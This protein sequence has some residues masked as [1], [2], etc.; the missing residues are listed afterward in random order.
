MKNKFFKKVIAICAV[1]CMSGVSGIMPANAAQLSLPYVNNFD[2]YEDVTYSNDIWGAEEG[3]PLGLNDFFTAGTQGNIVLSLTRDPDALERGKVFKIDVKARQWSFVNYKFEEY[4]TG[5]IL[6]KYDIKADNENKLEWQIK[7]SNGECSL[8]AFENNTATL[9]GAEDKTVTYARGEYNTVKHILD[10]DHKMMT[11]YFNDSS[12]EWAMPYFV[13]D[14]NLIPAFDFIW[15]DQSGTACDDTIYIDNLEIRHITGSADPVLSDDRGNQV[16]VFVGETSELTL[17][18]KNGDTFSSVPEATFVDL[19]ENA[20]AAEEREIPVTGSL[21]NGVVKYE[22]DEELTSGNRYSLKL[23]N[24]V[25]TSGQDL[26]KTE[27]DLVCDVNMGKLITTFEED[28][29]A[30]ESLNEVAVFGS[31]Y[32]NSVAKYM[33]TGTGFQIVE[34]SSYRGGK[35]LKMNNGTKAGFVLS[36]DGDNGFRN[37]IIE[38]EAHIIPSAWG[39]LRLTNGYNTDVPFFQFSQ[40]TI[41]N[42]YEGDTKWGS[43]AGD[44]VVK[45]RVNLDTG[46]YDVNYNGTEIE[47]LTFRSWSSLKNYGLTQFF[48]DAN[49]DSII[50]DYFTFKHIID[51]PVIKKITFVDEN[52]TES[53]YEAGTQIKNPQAV[54]VYFNQNVATEGLGNIAVTAGD[55]TASYTGS[56]DSANFVYTMTFNNGLMGGTEYTLSIPEGA[57][58]SAANSASAQAV[59]GKFETEALPASVK[60]TDINGVELQSLAAAGDTIN[61]VAENVTAADNKVVIVY[62]GYNGQRLVEMNFTEVDVTA[63]KLTY[64]VT[65]A[66]KAELTNVRAFVLDDFESLKPLCVYDEI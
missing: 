40:D 65:F 2:I 61:I 62:A 27:F 44:I 56:Y 24:V 38:T 45:H 15:R 54:K 57:V 13:T 3:H 36:V 11:T 42:H 6:V 5:K 51:L 52:G 32:G 31:V 14:T 34:D 33:G 20:V 9:Y 66:D 29:G 23:E 22:L 48:F 4:A 18:L 17:S 12:I 47:D 26:T 1:A 30:A 28:F 43:C 16:D 53:R 39:N 25:T 37:G 35:A 7:G 64:P 21:S 55:N 63:N 19:G 49:G 59:S 10:M 58:K 46:T 41:A 8:I 60:I 50:V